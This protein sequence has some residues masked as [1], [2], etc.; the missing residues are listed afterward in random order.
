MQEKKE[1][2]KV[3]TFRQ[4]NEGNEVLNLDELMNVQG[5]DDREPERNCGLG[6]YLAGVG[7]TTQTGSDKDGNTSIQP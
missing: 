4:C 2:K 6:C 7:Q 1:E 3:T 5:G